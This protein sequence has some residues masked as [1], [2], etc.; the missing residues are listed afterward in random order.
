MKGCG[1]TGGQAR[2]RV[3]T[4][5]NAYVVVHILATNVDKC[6]GHVAVHH[7]KTI[8]QCPQ[9][10]REHVANTLETTTGRGV[11]LEHDPRLLD[12]LSDHAS[13]QKSTAD[14]DS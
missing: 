1:G 10:T 13:V 3:G 9:G 5:D 4:T 11:G 7:L 2:Y 8:I 14:A 12:L 6:M